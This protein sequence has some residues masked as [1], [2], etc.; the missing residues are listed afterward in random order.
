MEDILAMATRLSLRDKKSL[1]E[2][3]LKLQEECG[4]LAKAV[5]PYVG[6]GACNHRFPNR[7]KIIEECADVLL[8]AYSIAKSL[9]VS[10]ADLEEVIRRKA[11]YWE[12]L[13]DVEAETDLEQLQFEVHITVAATSNIETFTRD[14]RDIGVKP[15]ILDLYTE[16]EPIVDV[17]TSSHMTGNTKQ[18]AIYSRGLVGELQSRGYKVLREKIETVPWHP[19][20]K[21][22][23][24]NPSPSRYF[25]AHLAFEGS[26]HEEVLAPFV[27]R[28]HIHLSR[29]KMKKAGNAVIMGTYRV[30]S[31][32]TD[33]E[34]F[35]TNVADILLASEA[36][37]IRV[38]ERP[39]TEF[40]LFDTN[41]V[42][43]ALWAIR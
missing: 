28:H 21:Q 17:M 2:K 42:H 25:E 7:D 38:T 24:L 14:C 8:V 15:I 33:V 41:T 16:G 40:A 19:A 36:S 35:K 11:L 6:A 23:H 12:S 22:A 10:D 20:S 32:D 18:A 4:E 29:N 34:T 3:A 26:T 39:V 43:D 1:S 13:Q 5:L 30:S 37:G 9:D 27:K 31:T